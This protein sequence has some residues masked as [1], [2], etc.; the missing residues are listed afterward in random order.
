MVDL[1]ASLKSEWWKADGYEIRNG[2]FCPKAGAT[3]RSYDPMASYWASTAERV[4]AGTLKIVAPYEDLFDRMRECRWDR[5]P[6]GDVLTEGSQRRLLQWVRQHGLLGVLPHRLLQLTGRYGRDL[7]NAPDSSAEILWA[8]DAENPDRV[9][10]EL[11]L[12]PKGR[13]DAIS[14]VTQDP[15]GV[16]ALD[17]LEGAPSAD[18]LPRCD[19]L[20]SA[21]DLWSE[22][23]RTAPWQ[24]VA[25]PFFALPTRQ[26]DGRSR[27]P[28]PGEN[29]F[30]AAYREPVAVFW[31][32]ARLLWR[33]C[34]EVGLVETRKD[35]DFLDSMG[36]HEWT[37]PATLNLL[38]SRLRP[39]LRPQGSGYEASW[40]SPSLLAI[41]A[42]QVY[43]DIGRGRNYRAAICD[44][45]QRPFQTRV[46]SA[47]F[48][49]PNC[50]KDASRASRREKAR[51]AQESGVVDP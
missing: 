34:Q 40:C 15:V 18:R 32:S 29:G 33:A 19:V 28:F 9:S 17:N 11:R 23:I 13:I 30:W 2:C 6:S 46:R 1:L 5:T 49:C 42:I 4:S 12:I 44:Y 20:A 41:L 10:A 21:Q 51:S 50:R 14:A 26:L 7:E 38:L 37:G 31:Q 48:C 43:W 36:V 24:E 3:V 47:R 39:S 22:E 27:Y 25:A 35:I 8:R 45:C 16:C